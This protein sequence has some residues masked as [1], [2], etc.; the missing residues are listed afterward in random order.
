MSALEAPAPVPLIEVVLPVHDEEVALPVAVDRLTRH[1]ATLPWSWLVTI[2][3]NASTDSTPLVA[4]RLAH[5]YE[6]VRVVTLPEKGRGRAL[7][8]VWQDSPADVLVYMDVD[9]STD[10]K[11]LMPLVA[12]L[13]SGH[14]DLSIGSRLSRSSRVVRG[15]KREL[16]SRSY[17]LLLRSTL[18]A[19]FSDAQC[20]FKAIRRDVADALLPLVEDDTWFFDTELL[21]LAERTGLRIHEVPVD[22]VDD[23]DSRVE[24]VRTAREDLAGIRRLGWALLTR[25]LPLEA[26]RERLGPARAAGRTGTQIGLFIVVGVLSTL[27]Y[28][29]L[30]LALRQVTGAQA[31]NLLALLLT[32][33]GNTAANRRFTF[34]VEGSGVVRHQAQGLLVFGLGLGVTSGTLAALQALGGA[35]HP[36]L[37]MAVLTAANLVVT[38]ARFVAMKWWIFRRSPV[39]AQPGAPCGAGAP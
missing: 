14:S 17:N 28:A 8:R 4:R 15:P 2:A 22:W 29:V 26:V 20:G 5:T 35:D 9:L 12:P 25:R 23:P 13:V 10:L 1:L 36:L 11:A 3:D 21:V 18:R 6:G 19:R 30:F 16:V 37:E 31:A 27:A 39:A 33:V 38:V 24:L 34:G 32:A 7:K